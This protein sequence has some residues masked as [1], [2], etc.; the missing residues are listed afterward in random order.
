[1][2]QFAKRGR[3]SFP[4]PPKPPAE[5]GGVTRCD[6]HRRV[7]FNARTGMAGVIPLASAMGFWPDLSVTA[8]DSSPED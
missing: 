7:R 2:R 5:A 6:H 3:S 1:M 4:A 8:S